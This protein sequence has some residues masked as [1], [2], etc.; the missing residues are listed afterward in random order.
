MI[1]YKIAGLDSVLKSKPE[2]FEGDVLRWK[3]RSSLPYHAEVTI[4]ENDEHNN[5]P[6]TD[7]AID[8]DLGQLETLS[9]DTAAPKRTAKRKPKSETADVQ[10]VSDDLDDTRVLITESTVNGGFVIDSDTAESE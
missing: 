6:A 2:N 8:S 7:S 4:L 5:Q 3:Q 10:P 1:T 9:E